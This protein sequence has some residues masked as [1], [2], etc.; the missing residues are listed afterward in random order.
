MMTRRGLFLAGST[1]TTTTTMT[2]TTTG[3]RP[4]CRL[5]LSARSIS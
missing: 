5:V 4:F 2:M 3:Y 1:T